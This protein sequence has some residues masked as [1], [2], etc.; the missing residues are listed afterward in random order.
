MHRNSSAH[1]EMGVR[2]RPYEEKSY[3][4]HALR[5]FW[6][7][8]GDQDRSGPYGKGLVQFY[9]EGMKKNSTFG[10]A[11]DVADIILIS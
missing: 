1:I 5:K 6:P 10:H 3:L 2:T 9:T 8:R 4:V 7:D 11:I